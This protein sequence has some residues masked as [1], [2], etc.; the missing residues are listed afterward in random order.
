[1]GEAVTLRDLVSRFRADR[2]K[3][4]KSPKTKLKQAAQDRLFLEALGADTLTSQLTREKARQ[5]QE[6]IARLPPNWTKRF[7]RLSVTEVLK[8]S[9]E[10]L[11]SPMS[12]GTANSYLTAFGALMEFAVNEHLIGRNTANGLRLAHGASKEKRRLPFTD[13][14]LCTVFSAPL[15]TGCVDDMRRYRTAGSNKPRRARFWI[16]LIA[17]FTGMRLNEICQLCEDDVDVDDGIDIILIRSAAD[18]SKRVIRVLVRQ[19]TQVSSLEQQ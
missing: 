1:M 19:R 9:D 13:G 3:K 4:T 6:I 2:S 10:Q 18:G 17:L 11:G 15:F 7:D 8:M 16:P 5:L 12:I 14:E